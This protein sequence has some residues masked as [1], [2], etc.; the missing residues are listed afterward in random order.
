[1]KLLRLTAAVWLLKS[2]NA[3]LNLGSAVLADAKADRPLHAS[4]RLLLA[5]LAGL[6]ICLMWIAMTWRAWG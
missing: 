3:L 2:G 4:E 6:A 5:S 1:M